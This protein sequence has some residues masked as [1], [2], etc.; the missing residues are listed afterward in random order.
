MSKFAKCQ[1]Q[2]NCQE[3][4]ADLSLSRDKLSE[5]EYIRTSISAV[6][7][8]TRIHADLSLSRDKLSETFEPD[9]RILSFESVRSK[10]KIKTAA[11]A[12]V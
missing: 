7:I 1:T 3:C 6:R 2:A 4:H 5:S 10:Q 12:T 11:N 9:K 8:S